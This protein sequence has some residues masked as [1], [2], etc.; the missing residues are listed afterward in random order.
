MLVP[1]CIPKSKLIKISPVKIIPSLILGLIFLVLWSCSDAGKD[2][3]SSGDETNC[4]QEIDCNNDCGG[5][6]VIDACNVCGGD[7]STCNISYLATIQPIFNAN[8]TGCHPSSAGLNL[9]SYSDLMDGGNS[10]LVVIPEDGAASYLIQ[11]LRG[12]NTISDSQMPASG[13]C[14]DESVIQLI[15]TWIDEGALDN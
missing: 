11:K 13:C 5:S 4:T 14:L 12:A 15:E 8:C 9:T 6:A 1:A 2:P 10:G 3:L 7:G